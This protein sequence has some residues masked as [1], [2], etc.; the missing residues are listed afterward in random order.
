MRHLKQKLHLS[1]WI[2]GYLVKNATTA[3]KVTTFA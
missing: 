2:L 1:H 3:A